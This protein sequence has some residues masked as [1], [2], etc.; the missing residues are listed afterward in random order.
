[1]KI[2]LTVYQKV[3]V[4]L[5]IAIAGITSL[6]YTTEAMNT[7]DDSVFAGCIILSAAIALVVVWAIKK[8]ITS[9]N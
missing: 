1:M 7:H 5:V 6:T 8:V 2:K 4:C 9:K 3:F